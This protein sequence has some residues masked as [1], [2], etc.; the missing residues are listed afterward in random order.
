VGPQGMCDREDVGF[1]STETI[2]LDSSAA[3]SKLV[4]PEIALIEV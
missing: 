2:L 1:N 4:P 3:T